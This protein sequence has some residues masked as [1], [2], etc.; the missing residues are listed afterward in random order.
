[1]RMSNKLPIFEGYSV[2]ICLKQFR[3]VNNHQII[4]ID[5]DSEEGEKILTRYIKS[6]DP[7]S[8]EFEQFIH[9]F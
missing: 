6:L 5:F 7:T 3:K 4:F 8:K 1:M 9:H 2:D